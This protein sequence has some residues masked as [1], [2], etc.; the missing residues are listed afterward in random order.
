MQK[1]GF[2]V[3]MAFAMVVVWVRLTGRWDEGVPRSPPG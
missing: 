3:G 2:A 1:R